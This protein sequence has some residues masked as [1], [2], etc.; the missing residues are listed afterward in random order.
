MFCGCAGHLDEFCFRHK[1]IEKRHL[2]Y[3]RN[4]YHGE[5]IDFLPR[6]YSHTLPRTSSHALPRFSHEPN[7]LSYDLSSQENNFV[8]RRIGYGTCPH[9]GD[10]FLRR[11][12]FPA[13]GSHTHLE[14]RHLDG[15]CFP[16]H[17]SRPTRSNGEV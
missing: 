11:L 1:R 3:T 8:P 12:S 7:H 2:D 9:R 13:G 6:S 5:F 10:R 17:G 14:P 15:P 4:S 16:H